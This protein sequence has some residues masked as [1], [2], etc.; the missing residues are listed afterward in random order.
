MPAA[1]GQRPF[2]RASQ[3][4]LTR[5]QCLAAQAGHGHDR[6]FLQALQRS[7][8]FSPAP[9]TPMMGTVSST[10]QGLDSSPPRLIRR[11]FFWFFADLRG[12]RNERRTVS[13]GAGRNAKDRPLADVVV[14]PKPG[15]GSPVQFEQRLSQR[16]PL[17]REPSVYRIPP[18]RLGWP[19]L[20]SE[21][22][23]QPNTQKV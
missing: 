4:D 18:T 7:A 1:R 13:S 11:A 6:Q 5:Q 19:W 8:D 16:D 23:L 2:P 21:L 20:L 12:M 9:L 22:A 14:R 15:D 17:I 10:P 3:A